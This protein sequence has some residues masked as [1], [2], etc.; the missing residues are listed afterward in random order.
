MDGG[1]RTGKTSALKYLPYNVGADKTIVRSLIR[2]EILQKE[3][4]NV[5]DSETTHICF[6]VPLVQKYIEKLIE[7]EM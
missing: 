4:V 5:N 3:I 6:Q 1:R 7:D 2:K